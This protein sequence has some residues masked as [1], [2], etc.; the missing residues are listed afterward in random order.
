M[1]NHMEITGG[2]PTGQPKDWDEAKQGKCGTLSVLYAQ[3]EATGLATMTSAWKPTSAERQALERD[4]VLFLQIYGRQHPVIA[5]WIQDASGKPIDL[6]A[7]PEPEVERIDVRTVDSPGGWDRGMDLQSALGAAMGELDVQAAEGPLTVGE[8]DDA[9]RVPVDGIVDLKALCEAVLE[10]IQP[11]VASSDVVELPIQTLDSVA[12]EAQLREELERDPDIRAAM[13]PARRCREC[14]CD[15]GNPCHD[16]LGNACWWAEP[17]L[18]AHCSS[19]WAVPLPVDHPVITNANAAVCP[20]PA[21][22]TENQVPLESLREQWQPLKCSGCDRGLE[23]LAIR[24]GREPSS[25]SG[26]AIGCR[27]MSRLS[28][29]GEN[30]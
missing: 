17:D 6:E 1:P 11:A 4:G 2:R 22:R 12:A 5:M 15:N 23:Y 9:G 3:D 14:G 29:E 16:G 27:R 10:R 28:P 21:C 7:E 30:G 19:N 13:D 25:A 8:I 18:C 24:V 20:A 26:F